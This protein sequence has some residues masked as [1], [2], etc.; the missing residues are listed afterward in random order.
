MG[1]TGETVWLGKEEHFE[2]LLERA[3]GDI[4]FGGARGSSSRPG[5]NLALAGY[6]GR[7]C[8]QSY[9]PDG[10]RGCRIFGNGG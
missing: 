9:P 3:P 2:K 8:L 5:A 10:R 1:A 4:G 6:D 7:T